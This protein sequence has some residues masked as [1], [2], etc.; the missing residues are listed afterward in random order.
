MGEVSFCLQKMGK[1]QMALRHRPFAKVAHSRRAEGA[2]NFH[3]KRLNPFPRTHQSDNESHNLKS[4]NHTTRN[5]H[6]PLIP[7]CAS[8]SKPSTR[9]TC[10]TRPTKNLKLETRNSSSHNQ[11]IKQSQIKQSNNS[12]TLTPSASAYSSPFLSIT[13]LMLY[14][15]LRICSTLL[16]NSHSSILK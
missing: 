11:T 6:P 4:N 1:L 14:P 12:Q 9:S 8:A 10:S 13:S 5:Q 16:V 15:Y 7:L 3:S 2:V